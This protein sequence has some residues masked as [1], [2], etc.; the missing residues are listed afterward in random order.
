MTESRSFACSSSP[1]RRRIA[2]FSSVRC[3]MST[4][5]YTTNKIRCSAKITHNANRGSIHP[6]KFC[7]RRR[8][9]PA[10]MSAAMPSTAM[11][12]VHG[13]AGSA[14]KFCANV[15]PSD[16]RA[17]STGVMPNTH[18]RNAPTVTF[19]S[20]MM[21]RKNCKLC[22]IPFPPTASRPCRSRL[23]CPSLPARPEP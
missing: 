8:S 11:A 9:T 10:R 18:T 1:F 5:M 4:T 13:L 23:H 3:P 16:C 17:A 12:S 21:R 20:S 15:T 2:E 14:L 7:P 6:M 22:A 19:S